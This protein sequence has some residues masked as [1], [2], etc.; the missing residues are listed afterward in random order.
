[1]VGPSTNKD[2]I[3]MPLADAFKHLIWIV[4]SFD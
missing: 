1:M 4:L 3:H 2:D